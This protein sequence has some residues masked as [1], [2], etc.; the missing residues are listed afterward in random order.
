MA[1]LIS[2]RDIELA[3]G[4][5]NRQV[6]FAPI[7]IITPAAR[8]RARELGIEILVSKAMAEAPVPAG[9]GVARAGSATP[10]EQPVYN[11]SRLE[12]ANSPVYFENPVIDSLMNICLELGAALWVTRDRLR[13]IE[14]LLGEQGIATKEQIEKYKT[15]PE[16]ERALMDQRNE[17]IARIFSSIR[18]L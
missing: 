14:A 4:A 11:A 8:D 3:A 18:N 6:A 10:A 16:M 5:G 15:P 2:A 13:V 7:D 1:K 9:A 12:P 17:F